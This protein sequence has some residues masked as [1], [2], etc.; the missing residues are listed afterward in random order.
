MSSRYQVDSCQ[1]SRRQ[2][3]SGHSGLSSLEGGCTSLLRIS[4]ALAAVWSRAARRGRFGARVRCGR[5]RRAAAGRRGH[6]GARSC[7]RG[8]SDLPLGGRVSHLC[9]PDGSVDSNDEH[10]HAY[11]TSGDAAGRRRNVRDGEP[12]VGNLRWHRTYGGVP[13]V[14]FGSDVIRPNPSGA[15]Q[16]WRG[17]GGAACGDEAGPDS[18]GQP[19]R[20]GRTE[21]SRIGVTDRW[22]PRRRLPPR[23]DPTR[24]R[25]GG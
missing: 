21:W 16:S 8:R 17:T 9:A 10:V 1:A 15:D 5:G 11:R 3:L 12:A 18:V 22:R 25:A 20:L 24:I 6:C 19:R 4:N 2:A 7:A 23:S 13:D 14:A